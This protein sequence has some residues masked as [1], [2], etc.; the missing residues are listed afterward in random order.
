MAINKK[1]ILVLG[2][3]GIVIALVIG[4][5]IWTLIEA[6]NFAF[7]NSGGDVLIYEEFITD[8]YKEGSKKLISEAY[9]QTNM[10]EYIKKS[11]SK[12]WVGIFVNEGDKPIIKFHQFDMKREKVIMACQRVSE[13]EFNCLEQK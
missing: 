5:M 3:P 4:K 11:S 9:H 8:K 6:K 10:A 1:A 12:N 2:V 13:T 7:I